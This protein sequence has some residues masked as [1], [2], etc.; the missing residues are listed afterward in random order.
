M[1]PSKHNN[2]DGD[3]ADEE[4]EVAIQRGVEEDEDSDSEQQER[5]ASHAQASTRGSDETMPDGAPAAGVLPL[6]F[7][8][9]FLSKE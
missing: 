3:D 4:E 6:I 7:M 1:P 2:E 9:H 8:Q 5:R